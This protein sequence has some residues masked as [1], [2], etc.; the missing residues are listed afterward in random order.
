MVIQTMENNEEILQALHGAFNVN[1][2]G[3][4]AFVDDAAFHRLMF[5]DAS[6]IIAII[7]SVSDFGNMSNAEKF[8]TQDLEDMLSYIAKTGRVL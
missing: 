3:F 7:F 6:Y 8:L 1:K 2:R 4:K 5:C